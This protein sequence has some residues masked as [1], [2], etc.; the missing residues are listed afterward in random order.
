MPRLL[1]GAV[2]ILGGLAAASV[3]LYAVAADVVFFARAETAE[4]RV[5]QMRTER[6]RRSV[7]H[8]ADIQF[9]TTAGEE[10]RVPA[11]R[12]NG[13]MRFAAG[14]SVR[15][16]YDPADPSRASIDSLSLH[17]LGALIALPFGIAFVAFGWMLAAGQ[18]RWLMVA[19]AGSG[20]A[21]VLLV[22]TLVA[23]NEIQ[24]AFALERA[25]IRTEGEVIGH[26]AVTRSSA[27]GSAETLFAPRIRFTAEDG[28]VLIV[29]PPTPSRRAEPPAGTRVTMRY[30]RDQ[31]ERA[32]PDRPAVRW[33]RPVAAVAVPLLLRGAATG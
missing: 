13:W 20:V 4:G 11:R 22:A 5:E 8:V 30:R 25:N 23:V 27:G 6:R 21:L 29:E 32:M 15:V 10:M 18:P 28:R 19:L 26:R 14:D 9:V 12:P 7:F 24:Q 17:I 31:P 2:F 33:L 16:R 1:I 3:G